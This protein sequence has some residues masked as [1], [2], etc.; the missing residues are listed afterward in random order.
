MYQID[1]WLML[2][3]CYAYRATISEPTSRLGAIRSLTAVQGPGPEANR[4]RNFS[5]QGQRFII[6]RTGLKVRTGG[7]VV[8]AAHNRN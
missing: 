2:Y 1:T 5:W 7:L 4:M 3:T 6:D 8:I